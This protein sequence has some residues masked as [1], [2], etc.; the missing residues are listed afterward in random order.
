MPD[1]ILQNDKYPYINIITESGL[2]AFLGFMYVRGLLG[3]TQSQAKKL[4]SNKIGHPIFSAT[5]SDNRMLV[6]K[7]MLT[8]DDP[9]TR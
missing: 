6:I 8:F 2:L 9:E 5:T 7:A 4:F 1:E 3:Q